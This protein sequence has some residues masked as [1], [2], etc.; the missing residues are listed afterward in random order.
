VP[1][2]V[3]RANHPGFV[4]LQSHPATIARWPSPS[5]TPSYEIR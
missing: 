5:L 1:Q 2:P 4:Q 3:R